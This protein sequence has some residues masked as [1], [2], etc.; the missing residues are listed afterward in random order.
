MVLLKPWTLIYSYHPFIAVAACTPLGMLSARLWNM[1]A[2]FCS[3]LARSS[4]SMSNLGNY[5][6]LNPTLYTGALSYWKRKE[7]SPNYWKLNNSWKLLSK[8]SLNAVAWRFPWAWTK[9]SQAGPS[10]NHEKQPKTKSAKVCEHHNGV[11]II[12]PLNWTDR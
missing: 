5:S 4:F 1:A 3:H 10:S 6:F 11:F 9:P 12:Q 8:I 2:G 7:P